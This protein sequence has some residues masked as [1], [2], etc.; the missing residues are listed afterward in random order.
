MLPLDKNLKTDKLLCDR[1]AH[2]FVFKAIHLSLLTTKM[3]V[4]LLYTPELENMLRK[5][6]M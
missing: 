4:S 5:A 2:Y 3:E 1:A 6:R